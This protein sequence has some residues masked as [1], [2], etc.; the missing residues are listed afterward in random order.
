M[1]G[2]NCFVTKKN[3]YLL[4]P[5]N[6]IFTAVDFLFVRCVGFGKMGIDIDTANYIG[7]AYIA[8]CGILYAIITAIA[9]SQTSNKKFLLFNIFNLAV[10]LLI[11]K[12]VLVKIWQDM[13][14]DYNIYPFESS[15]W[16]IFAWVV[17]LVW[18]CIVRLGVWFKKLIFD[19]D[20]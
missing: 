4:L 1:N 11:N 2:K 20:L 16:L 5:A 7:C 10:S 13:H 3:W 12:L 8:A 15:Q 6:L 19:F 17:L 9:Y 18:Q 14:W